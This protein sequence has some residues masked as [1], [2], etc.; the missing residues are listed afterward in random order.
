MDAVTGAAAA[1]AVA[2]YGGEG[3]E[4]RGVK[5]GRPGVDA[6]IAFLT[7]GFIS[8]CFCRNLVGFFSPAVVEK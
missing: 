3:E 4:V 5:V 2:R 6:E 7:A 1:A 8:R